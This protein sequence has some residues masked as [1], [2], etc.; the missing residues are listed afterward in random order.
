MCVP[1]SPLLVSSASCALDE[2]EGSINE[3]QCLNP[4]FMLFTLLSTPHKENNL[5]NLLFN[6]CNELLNE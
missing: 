1:L 5:M 4:L 3:V 6:M 2:D